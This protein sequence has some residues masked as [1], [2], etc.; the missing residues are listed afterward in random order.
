MPAIQ[1]AFGNLMISAR[2]IER[3]FRS[4]RDNALQGV[5]GIKALRK[6]AYNRLSNGG[7]LV[8]GRFSDH[9]LVFDPG[10]L[11]GRT[12]LETGSFERERTLRVC[13]RARSL[14]VKTTVLEIGS[15]IGSQTVYLLLPGG[16]ATAI[17]LE[18]DPKNISLF[19]M[20]VRLNNLVDRVTL[21]P[22][23]AGAE[24]GQL[25]LRRDAGNSGGATLRQDRLPQHVDSEIVVPVETIDNLIT[26]GLIDPT[27]IGLIWM[28]AEGF[29]EEIFSACDVLLKARTP[30]AFEFTPGFY[31]DDQRRKIIERIF[32]H[33]DDVSVITSSG[34][35]PLAKNDGLRLV[36]RVDLFCC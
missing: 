19:E 10:D 31:S 27:T 5:M 28:D 29:E 2:R 20:N 1:I 32:A 25:V 3:L 26:Q 13:K 35:S 11:V 14:T 6:A 7:M 22:A 23:A 18:P 36:R 4:F 8:V 12:I 15:N 33:Y 17:C 16:F 21:I 34:F 24:I 30:L 9:N